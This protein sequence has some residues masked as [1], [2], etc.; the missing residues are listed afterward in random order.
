M[1]RG[2]PRSA[3]ETS[4][5]A[6]FPALDPGTN[7][8]VR[9]PSLAG[10]RG[11]ALALLAAHSAD[12][13][14]VVLSIAADARSVR[15][16]LLAAG[17]RAVSD[18]CYV[19]DGVRSQMDGGTVAVT[20]GGDRR[21]WYVTS[22]SNLTGLGVST[23]RAL[24]AIAEAGRRPRLLVDSLSTLLQYSS[25]D[26]VYRFLHVLNGRV[27]AVDGVTVQVIHADAHDGQTV[28]TLAHL[29]DSVLDVRVEDDGDEPTVTVRASGPHVGPSVPL[30]ELLDGAAEADARSTL[31]A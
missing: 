2:S 29:F 22:P 8:L 10:K 27:A 14:P 3:A 20:D 6:A 23:T 11:L 17:D 31:T 26:R 16:R 12:E 15:Q 21:T 25:L 4:G 18:R 1:T 24:S 7:V 28:A 30:D 9:G 19:I 13:R 5:S